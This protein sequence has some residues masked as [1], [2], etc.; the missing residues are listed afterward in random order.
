MI[1]SDFIDEP[2][3]TYS[4]GMV[5]R[6]AFSVAINVDPDILIVDEAMGAGDQAFSAKCFDRLLDFRRAG[7]TLMVVSHSPDALRQMCDRGIWLDHGQVILDG[8]L[9]E[10][11]SAY[12]G[13]TV[14][15]V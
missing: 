1:N 12:Q 9:E 6:L 5:M 4:T 14:G 7:K 13:R 3:R 10:V 11:L 15:P 8:G 2:L